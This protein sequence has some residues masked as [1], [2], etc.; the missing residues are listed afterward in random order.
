MLCQSIDR[1]GTGFGKPIFPTQLSAS[2]TLAD[3]VTQDSWFTFSLLH[4]QP[5]F[6][7][8]DVSTWEDNLSF[9]AS[10]ANLKA[11][12]VVND[13]AERGIKLSS[14]FLASS[15]VE[16]QYQS[17]LQVVAKSR[18]DQPNLRRKN[19]KMRKTFNPVK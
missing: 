7:S 5:D 11:V 12:N 17:N 19:I 10:K 9:K 16:V 2:T 6:L 4:L 13:A 18:C 15:K 14:D 1:F 3:L 8:E